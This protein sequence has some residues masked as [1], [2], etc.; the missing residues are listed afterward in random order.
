[1]SLFLYNTLSR[2]KEAF[3]PGDPRRVT[4]YVCG[5]TVYSYAHIGNARP[6]VVFDV[7]F[8]LLRQRYPQV[9]YA[10]NVTDVDDKINAAARDQA[11]AIEV[12]SQRFTDIYRT[13][14]AALGAL[15]PTVEPCAT[16]HIPQ[17]V[18]MIQRLIATGHA[19]VARDHVLF[20]VP[21]F[22]D[23]GALSKRERDDM[24]AG[25]RVEV[26]P[27]KKD[28]AD[29]VLWKPSSPDMPGW[30]SPWGR[31]R[32]G[33]HIE[34]SSMIETHLGETIDIH[35][36]GNDLIFPHHENELA[37]STC[38]HNAKPLARV[39]MH[40]GFLTI[41]AAKMSKSLGNVVTVHALLKDHPGESIRWALLSAHYRQPLDWS[42]ETLTQATRTLN[43]IYA[44][45]DQVADTPA[46][47]GT[48]PAGLKDALDDDLNTPK[49]MAE[50]AALAHALNQ[51]ADHE[52][53][54]RLKGELLAAGEVLGVLQ[55]APAAW[56]TNSPK[57]KAVDAA[58]V[59]RLIAARTAARQARDFAEADRIRAQISGL[60]VAIEDRADGTRWR[61]ME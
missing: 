30:E 28:P 6:V 38:A 33:W 46:A 58:E 7:L 27:F 19:Y 52:T 36:G 13:D 5:P 22:T 37:Q 29:F 2:R 10:R 53:K 3:E 44:T 40:N 26:A 12:V 34:C 47:K 31:G 48:I 15:P 9:V 59:E 4:M 16:Q 11:V 49:A 55:Q 14:M 35:G 17:M 57:A 43:R 24:V 32:P 45:L 56:F 1:M 61:V 21:G 60:G 23:Y 25:A 39:W 50:I 18:A 20:H 42:D 8:R 54:A 41:D 51:A